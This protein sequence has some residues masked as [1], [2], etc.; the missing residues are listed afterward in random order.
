[1]RVRNYTTKQIY[2][3]A[4]DRH[5]YEEAAKLGE[6]LSS[7]IAEALREYVGRRYVSELR[8]RGEEK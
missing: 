8:D 3:K 4:E 7:V 5:L 6:S 1:M 2:V